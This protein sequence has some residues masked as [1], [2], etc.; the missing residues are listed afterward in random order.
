M[1]PRE[2]YDATEI[3]R[4]IL[5]AVIRTGQ[6]FGA[7]YIAQVLQGS[8]SKKVRENGHQELTVFGIARNSTD[9]DLKQV[10]NALVNQRMMVKSVGTY[11]TLS[12]TAEGMAFL[13]G[14]ESLTLDRPKDA[15]G[16]SSANS[17]DVFPPNLE[18]LEVL[19]DL[20]TNIADQRLAWMLKP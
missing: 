17:T 16:T 10:T 14:R 8:G 13:K 3:A 6:R 5:S 20:R 11:P 12:V 2:E 9:D 18:L 4:K 7:R 19:R 15:A 1:T